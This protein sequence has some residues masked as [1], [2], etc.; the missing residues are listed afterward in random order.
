LHELWS[1]CKIAF[2]QDSIGST[3]QPL[4]ATRGG[5]SWSNFSANAIGIGQTKLHEQAVTSRVQLENYELWKR[6]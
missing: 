4:Q 1:A 6:F 5:T 2:Q 3:A